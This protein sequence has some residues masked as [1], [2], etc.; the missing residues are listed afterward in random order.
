MNLTSSE[1][2]NVGI[3][4]QNFQKLQYFGLLMDEIDKISKGAWHHVKGGGAK[5]F[6]K[7]FMRLN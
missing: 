4:P 2:Y 5:N 7:M 3:T 1:T 6:A